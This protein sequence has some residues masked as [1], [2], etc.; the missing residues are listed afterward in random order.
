MY[1]LENAEAFILLDPLEGGESPNQLKKIAQAKVLESKIDWK[2]ELLEELT[3]KVSKYNET[4]GF[5]AITDEV[6]G[7]VSLDDIEISGGGGSNIHG[8][9]FLNYDYK[10]GGRKNAKLFQ[11]VVDKIVAVTGGDSIE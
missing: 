3:D 5:K 10:Y 11:G 2:A 7:D 8:R 9:M 6:Y 4:R 1:Y